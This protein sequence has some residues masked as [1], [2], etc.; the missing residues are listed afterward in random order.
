M[1]VID[2]RPT[3]PRRQVHLKDKWRNLNK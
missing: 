2:A 1:G 3:T